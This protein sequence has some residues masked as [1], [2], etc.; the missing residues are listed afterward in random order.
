MHNYAVLQRTTS[1]VGN[2][3]KVRALQVLFALTPPTMIEA[4]SGTTIANIRSATPP[5]IS[6]PAHPL[7]LLQGFHA[8][9]TICV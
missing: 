8:E 2:V 7:L 5:P 6:S 4:I 3:S 9:C 1:P